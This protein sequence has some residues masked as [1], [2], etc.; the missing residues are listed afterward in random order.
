MWGCGAWGLGGRVEGLGPVRFG[1]ACLVETFLLQV[2]PFVKKQWPSKTKLKIIFKPEA[3]SGQQN[4]VKRLGMAVPRLRV[5]RRSDLVRQVS[6][7]YRSPSKNIRPTCIL[8]RSMS[9]E[10]KLSPI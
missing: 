8:K 9:R 6:L 7:R 10:I 3:G 1:R 5:S 4:Q 2:T